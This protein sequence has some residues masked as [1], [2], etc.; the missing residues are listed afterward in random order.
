MALAVVT[1]DNVRL[2]TADNTTNWNDSGG[3]Q[4]GTQEPD[5]FYQGS[6]SYARKISTSANRGIYYQDP[7]TINMTVAG[8]R[9][10]LFKYI[11]TNYGSAPTSTTNGTGGIGIEIGS[12]TNAYVTNS[13]T[14]SDTYPSRGGFLLRAF[15]P[16]SN[17][18]SRTQGSPNLS[19]VNYFGLRAITA[20]TAT[21]KEQNVALDAVDIGAGLNLVGGT[22]P[23]PAGTFASFVDFDQNTT[24]NRFGY[25]TEEGGIIFGQGKVVIG[26]DAS[27]TPTT[28]RFDDAATQ[29]VFV[30][31][32]F[33]AGFSG[34]EF[35]LSASLTDIKISN[36]NISSVGDKNAAEDTRAI[37]NVVGSTGAAMIED[38]GFTGF[39]SFTN[40][41]GIMFDR[42]S[43]VTCGKFFHNG[44]QLRDCIVRQP[45]V[46]A[47]DAFVVTSDPSNIT[48]TS[49]V[50][51]TDG[52]AIEITQP[53]TYNFIGNVFREY[54]PTVGSNLVPNSGASNAAVLNS[55]G[56]LVVLNISGGGEAPS[57]RNTAGS[58]TEVNANVTVNITGL[59]DTTFE[60]NKTE[61]RAFG[62][63]TGTTTE[64]AGIGTERH[65]PSI[66]SFTIAAGTTFDLRIINLDY[67]PFFLRDQTAV[68]DPTNI[69]V[70]LR[71]DRV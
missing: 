5:F 32:L 1:A 41:A 24:A 61:I 19:A 36:A 42:C 31:G 7:G 11:I 34:I 66:Y 22:S 12:G 40:T 71:P 46:V 39:E 54:D 4:G 57:I 64:V 14:G 23:D 55:S 70:S 51:G 69:P 35:D 27:G 30:D 38:S 56:G 65:E 18:V 6:F 58:T 3:C 8:R 15:A 47:N 25:I 50:A 52:H 48:N 10:M 13:S 28:T 60:T 44:A 62:P 20:F 43:F 16:N 53:G 68:A 67:V 2:T 29:I 45:D 21:A 26:R 9:H 59:P 33:E 63:G 49:F 17:H 37:F